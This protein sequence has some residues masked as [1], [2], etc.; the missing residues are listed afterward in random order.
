MPYRGLFHRPVDGARQLFPKSSGLLFAVT[1]IGVLFTPIT[2][3]IAKDLSDQD[4]ALYR[5]AFHYAQHDEWGEAVAYAAKPRER[6]LAKVIRWMELARPKS[7]HSFSEIIAFIG[8]NPTWPNQTGLLRQAEETMPAEMP[9][10]AVA[11]WFEAH[12]PVSALGVGRYADALVA[13]GSRAKAAALVRRFWI[14][15]N[16]V[17][18]GDEIA[19]RHR[20]AA[21]LEPADHLARLDRVLWEHQS[22]AARRMFSLVDGDHRALAVA[23]IALADDESDVEGAL[24]QVPAALLNDA[25]LSYERLHW[26][27]VKANYVGALELLNHPPAE[28]GR[29]ALWWVERNF[30]ARHLFE[31]HNAEAAYSQVIAH[32]FREGQPLA[33][34][35]FFAGWLAL[36]HLHQPD[37]ALA[38]FQRMF[39]AVTMPM[40]RAR[41][42][43][44]CGR[45][46]DAIGEPG[47]AQEWYGK[48]AAFPT[49]FYGQLASAALRPAHPLVI[50]VEPAV[51]AEEA[52]RFSRRG[53][54]QVVRLLHEIDPH[55]SADRV[56][57]F[58][59][60][61]VRDAVS[62]ADW[63]LLGRLALDVHQ[64]DEAIYV[65]KQAI[66][67]G[68]VLTGSGYP[69]LSFRQSGAVEK[70]LA[71][72]LIRQ[73]STFNNRIVS[74][75]GARG[76]MQLMPNTATRLAH[77]LKLRTMPTDARLSDDND[78]NILLGTNEIKELIDSYRSS[79]V[80]A[81]AGYNAGSGR[82]DDWLDEFGDPRQGVDPIDWIESIPFAET[83]NYVQRGLEALQ[84]YRARL[85]QKGPNLIQ[86]LGLR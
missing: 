65:A 38:H 84:V 14:E 28:L 52:A 60:R 33:E 45:A 50:P 35:E 73:E 21:L 77:K 8:A 58:L 54:V 75:A 15:A 13:L 16:F 40:S 68:V 22:G 30:L 71:L 70:G 61:M 67:R 1:V 56:G 41:A 12:G 82:V 27:R 2:A 7:G 37:E 81:L 80:L 23:R 39:D 26:R 42:A 59:R 63:V 76:L 55:D 66:Q 44:W 11:R 78:L 51:S 9:A 53:L 19:F 31:Q 79:Y 86:D 17:T 64:P 57:L 83:R 47:E 18:D 10:S 72:S 4:L 32:G 25:G 74:S 69:M 6:L 43:Y 20:F 85:G 34:A 5:A 49:M 46:A 24:R 62:P 36:R 48:A 29:P 3:G